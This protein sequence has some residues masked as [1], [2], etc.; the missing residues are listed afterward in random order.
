MC[1]SSRLLGN[2]AAVTGLWLHLEIP[3]GGHDS[4][5]GVGGTCK[6]EVAWRE[7]E[8]V[9]RRDGAGMGELRVLTCLEKKGAGQLPGPWGTGDLGCVLSPLPWWAFFL[10]SCV[11]KGEENQMDN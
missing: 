8:K 3:A 2:V 7:G 5:C 9:G 1:I 4:L 6:R 11:C 10:H